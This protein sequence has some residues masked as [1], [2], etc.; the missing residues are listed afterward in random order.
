MF[1]GEYVRVP[2][3][4]TMIRWSVEV[5]A[6]GATEPGYEPYVVVTVSPLEAV[7]VAVTVTAEAAAV[8]VELV[9]ELDPIA[10]AWNAANLASEPGLTA[11]TIPSSQCPV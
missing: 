5:A 9:V 10:A 8:E 4:P 3:L 2:L 6:V 11:N 7:T 1:E